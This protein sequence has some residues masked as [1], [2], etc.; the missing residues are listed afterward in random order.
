MTEK[1]SLLTSIP[2]DIYGKANIGEKCDLTMSFNDVQEVSD[3]NSGPG[4][5]QTAH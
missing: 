4:S 2:A 3:S 5:D 1:E